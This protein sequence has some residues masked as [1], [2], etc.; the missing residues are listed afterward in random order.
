MENKRSNLNLLDIFIL[1][2]IFF[3]Q[4]IYSS[5][6]QYLQLRAEQ[7]TAPTELVFTADQNI[8]GI[9]N[10]LLILV[11]AAA[12]LFYRKFDFRFFDLKVDRHTILKT[13]LY[14]LLVSLVVNI[15]D[16]VTFSIFPSDYLYGGQTATENTQSLKQLFFGNLSAS[17]VIFA[18]LNGFFEEIFFLGII[19]AVKKP[20]LPY[21]LFFSL[22]IRFAFHTYQGLAAAGSITLLGVVFLLLRRNQPQL[23]PFMLSHSI[24][25]LF[26]VGFPLQY[27]WYLSY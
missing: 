15:Y 13:F 22:I 10:E 9:I 1:T 16:M 12:Y 3:G 24:F 27:L 25:D 7:Q 5:T 6:V 17:F 14:I 19:F 21:V 8:W 20:Y 11:C 26:G 2:L 23:L 18:L 4:A